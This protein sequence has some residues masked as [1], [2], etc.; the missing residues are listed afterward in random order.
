MCLPS[1]RRCRPAP[2]DHVRDPAVAEVDP[3]EISDTISD[4]KE[5]GQL[6]EGTSE[7]DEEVRDRVEDLLSE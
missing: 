7:D 2:R 1:C 5:S 4:M 3:D 6:P